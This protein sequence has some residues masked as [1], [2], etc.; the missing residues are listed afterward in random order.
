[1]KE[2]MFELSVIPW[3]T[4]S[5]CVVW[6]SVDQMTYQ[7]SGQPLATCLFL[8]SSLICNWLSVLTPKIS[9]LHTL[10][11]SQVLWLESCL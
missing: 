5:R 7:R 1:V 3:E 8:L 11:H 2:G 10:V 6:S 4:W 9:I